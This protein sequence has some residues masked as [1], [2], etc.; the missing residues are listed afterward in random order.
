MSMTQTI[1]KF[2]SVVLV[3]IMLIG[4][5]PT[6]VFAASENVVDTAVI[7]SDLHTKKSDYK[8]S[9]L[10]NVMSVLKN[11]GM[12][13]SSVTSA[14]DAFSVNEDTNPKDSMRN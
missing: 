6:T 4:M 7:F 5:V 9:T 11:S 14:G 13:I 3:L 8:E 12:H 2:F 10:K 1:K